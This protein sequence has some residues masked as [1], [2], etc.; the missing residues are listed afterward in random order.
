ML[1]LGI[2][3]LLL[4]G[5]LALAELGMGSMVQGAQHA[6]VAALVM[7]PLVIGAALAVVYSRRQEF[8]RKTVDRVETAA[9]SVA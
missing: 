8:A 3:G 9:T 2:V 4:G 1:I 6:L 7:G 5:I